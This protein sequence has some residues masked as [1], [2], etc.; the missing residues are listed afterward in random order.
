MIDRM[1]CVRPLFVSAPAIGSPEA[2]ARAVA[3]P[4]TTTI[5]TT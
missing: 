3:A 5:K 1:F 2:R 4:K